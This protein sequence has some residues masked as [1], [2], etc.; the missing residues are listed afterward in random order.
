MVSMVDFIPERGKRKMISVTTYHEITTNV[1]KVFKKYQDPDANLDEFPAD[2]H[3]LD[4]KYKSD[5][6][7]YEFMQ[8]LLKVYFDELNRIKG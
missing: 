4:Q 5:P 8:R 2:V 7:A 3:T 1:W 6:T